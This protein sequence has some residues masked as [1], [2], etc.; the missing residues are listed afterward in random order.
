MLRCGVALTIALAVAAFILGF[1]PGVDVYRG[2]DFIETRQVVERWNWSLGILVLLVAPGIVVWARPRIAYALLWSLW[3][4]ASSVIVFLATFDLGD[5]SVR[6][7]ELWPVKL[8]GLI[9][10]SLLFTIIA[11]I[12]I[13]C[14]VYWW[15][16][17]ERV[18]RIEL[19]TAR[20][21]KL[22]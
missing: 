11:V 20:V 9:I 19:P 16:T 2:N 6:T 17:R 14:A 15:V 18:R 8:F 12:P 5:W 13:A 22:A 10:F 3:T 4:I 7:V 1:F 21:I